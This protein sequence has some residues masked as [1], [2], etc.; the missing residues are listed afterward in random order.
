MIGFMA[1][2]LLPARIGEIVRAV[3]LS[4]KQQLSRSS[5]FATVV[6]ER[7]F[8]SL[9]LLSVFF[10]TLFAVDYPPELRR[11]GYGALALTAIVLAFLILLKV[12]TDLAI[13]A[14]SVPLRIVSGELGDRVRSILRKFADG[15]SIL[16]SPASIAVIYLY[17]VGL[18]I[19]TA[20]SSYLIFI[21]FDLT[22]SVW[23][24]F[25]LLFVTV[26]GVAL[27]SSPGYI[28]TFHAACMI[29]FDLIHSLGMFG[30]EV[31]KS[32]ALS[33]SVVLWSTQ[34]FPVTLIGLYYLRKEHLS[35]SEIEKAQ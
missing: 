8:D 35:F 33:Y 12:K 19:F 2:N 3:S 25:I 11:A 28:G 14:A 6:A 21:A 24:T 5:V 27:P 30:N 7:V 34:F 23:A 13:S 22:P 31:S 26:L 9:G 16:T 1:N 4:R 29:G 20:V 17:S 32:V 15:L 10:L 18:W